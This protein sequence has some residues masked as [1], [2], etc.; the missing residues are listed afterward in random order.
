MAGGAGL[1]APVMAAGEKAR[2]G[3][4]PATPAVPAAPTPAAPKA[5]KKAAAKAAAAAAASGAQAATAAAQAEQTAAAATSPVIVLCGA[6]NVGKS[7]RGCSSTSHWARAP[8]AYASS[9][10]SAR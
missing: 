10:P 4:A 8:R 5:K 6:R 7:S 2:A 1:A 9:R 3:A